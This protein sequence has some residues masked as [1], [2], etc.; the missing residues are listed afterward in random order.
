MERKLLN[1]DDDISTILPHRKELEILEGFEEDGGK[2]KLKAATGKITIRMLLTH[3]SGLAYDFAHPEVG[4]YTKYLNQQ[5]KL[6]NFDHLVSQSES[7]LWRSLLA[8]LILLA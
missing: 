2:P 8:N 3:S 7:R 6:S 4:K 5:G 1:L